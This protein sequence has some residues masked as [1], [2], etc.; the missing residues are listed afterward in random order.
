MYTHIFI[1]R[2]SCVILDDCAFQE[3]NVSSELRLNCSIWGKKE[4]ILP[5]K[6]FSYRKEPDQMR[7]WVLLYFILFISSPLRCLFLY[8]PLSLSPKSG[9]F[10]ASFLTLSHNFIIFLH[11][12]QN[13]HLYPPF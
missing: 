3:M 2:K 13:V 10:S 7:S 8:S 4:G 1:V 11:T 12:I 9:C 5:Q 6:H